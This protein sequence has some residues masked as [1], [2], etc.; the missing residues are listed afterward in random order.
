MQPP[1]GLGL[2]HEDILGIKTK[3]NGY[4]SK[5]GPGYGIFP[6]P[7]KRKTIVNHARM[8]LSFSTFPSCKSDFQISSLQ[9]TL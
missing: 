6:T 3:I 2:Y 4:V 7:Y 1:S 5:L 9:T 8:N